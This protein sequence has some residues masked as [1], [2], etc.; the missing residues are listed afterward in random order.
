MEAQ[1]SGFRF[2]STL[3]TGRPTSPLPRL[4][5]LGKCTVSGPAL[6][7]LFGGTAV[8][9]PYLLLPVTLGADYP[10]HLARLAV[11]GS[12][13][14]SPIRNGFVPHWALMPDLGLDLVYMA[15]RPVAS[16]DTV[17]RLCL[18][19]SLAAMLAGFCGIQK[20]LFGRLSLAAAVAPLVVAGLPVLMGYVNFV[21][22]CAFVVAGAWLSL[23]WRDRQSAPRVA[24]LAVLAAFAWLCHFAGF[25]VLVVFVAGLQVSSHPTGRRLGRLFRAAIVTGLVA[26]PGL[27]MSALA[28]RETEPTRFHYDILGVRS[29]FAPLVASGGPSDFLIWAGVLILLAATLCFGAWHIHR[30]ARLGGALLLLLVAVLPW[31]IGDSTVDVDARLAVP[32]VFLLLATSR[33]RAPGGTFGQGVAMLVL[34]LLIMQRDSALIHTGAQEAR[35]VA[36]FRAADKQL[37][38][39]AT[40]MVA[41][42]R[43]RLADCSRSD[44]PFAA[45]GPNTHLAAYAVIDRAAWEPFIFS[46]KGK[47]PVRS[48]K[49]FAPGELQTLAPPSLQRILH[50]LLNGSTDE[51][52]EQLAPGWPERY[53]FLLVLGRGCRANPSPSLLIPMTDDPAF[54]LYRVLHAARP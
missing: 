43:W 39:G 15:L 26:L 48:A 4:Q 44:T 24:T 25:A 12:A 16:A 32:A 47:Q 27:A 6:F 40:L 11:L 49:D 8:L 3:D 20:V 10:N 31:R 13:A 7:L 36:A 37:P 18:V 5:S 41:T 51:Y 29:L 2:L 42:D 21:M 23:K 52:K 17:L 22:S 14:S 34:A 1:D 35:I 45:I 53:D 46:A 54:S 38:E 28:E 50:P 9:L 30:S 19:G 33:L